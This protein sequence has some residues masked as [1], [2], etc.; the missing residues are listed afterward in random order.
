[1]ARKGSKASSS[2]IKRIISEEV[3]PM[4]GGVQTAPLD[5]R[6]DLYYSRV[7]GQLALRYKLSQSGGT[8]NEYK[9]ARAR[10]IARR[11]AA[12]KLTAGKREKKAVKGAPFNMGQKVGHLRC[13]VKRKEFKAVRRY[14]FFR[15][16][17]GSSRRKKMNRPNFTRRQFC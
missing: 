12:A 5:Q 8:E 6:D 4:I 2:M 9:V 7:A 17:S 15:I 10:R 14:N 16:G 1:M 13:R 3:V 11:S